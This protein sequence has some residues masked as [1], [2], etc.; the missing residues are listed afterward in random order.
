LLLVLLLA[1]LV[2]LDGCRTS[3]RRKGLSLLAELF[4]IW[5]FEGLE[6]P[7]DSSFEGVTAKLFAIAFA[8]VIVSALQFAFTAFGFG[9]LP[10]HLP[11]RTAWGDEF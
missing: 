3:S 10:R 8:V 5:L 9:L 11:A 7:R 1:L 2:S 4:G 6:V